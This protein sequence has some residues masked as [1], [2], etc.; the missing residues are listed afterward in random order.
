M[1]RPGCIPP[2]RPQLLLRNRLAQPAAVACPL[3]RLLPRVGQ[4]GCGPTRPRYRRPAPAPGQGHASATAPLAAGTA[5]G[6]SVLPT[7]LGYLNFTAGPLAGQ[8]IEVPAA[9]L[10]LGREPGSGGLAI[11]DSRVSRK[12]CWIGP[13]SDGPG[14]VIVD[15]GSTNGTFVGSPAAGRIQQVG[16]K[17]GDKVFLGADGGVV[18]SL[19]V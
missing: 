7:A 12:H 4:P 11:P 3:I 13:A 16:L 18:F 5:G 10:T 6:T 19:D 15:Q 17:P 2:P 14:V 1:N 8:R 9:G